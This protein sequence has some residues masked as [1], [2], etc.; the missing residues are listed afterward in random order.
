MVPV[1]H[2]LPGNARNL[3]AAAAGSLDSSRVEELVARVASDSDR[4]GG[5]AADY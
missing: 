3:A 1:S 5:N 4:A 2:Q